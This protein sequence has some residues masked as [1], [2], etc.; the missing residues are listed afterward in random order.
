MVAVTSQLADVI[1]VVDGCTHTAARRA[2]IRRWVIEIHF[3]VEHIL[4]E[5]DPY[6]PSSLYE[7]FY[8]I[9]A[10]MALTG[11]QRTAHAVAGVHGPLPVVKQLPERQISRV[12]KVERNICFN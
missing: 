3:W 11:N 1:Y 12:R 9:I 7:R 8:H 10:Q 2:W 6:D 5:N 4:G